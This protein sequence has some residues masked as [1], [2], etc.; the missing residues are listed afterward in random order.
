[1]F[2]AGEHAQNDMAI[3]W[4]QALEKEGFEVTTLIKGLGQNPDVQ[5]LYINH[6]KFIKANKPLDIEQKK[7]EYAAGKE[8]Q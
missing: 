7:A 8:K 5:N 2:V 4:K 3:K 6:L 1:M